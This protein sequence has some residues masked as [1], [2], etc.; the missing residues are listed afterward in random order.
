M[1]VRMR[2]ILSIFTVVAAGLVGKAAVTESWDTYSDTWVATDDLGREV[3]NCD[4]DAAQQVRRP[5]EV[6]MFY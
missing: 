1:V 5:S 4:S 3:Y 6:G 2:H